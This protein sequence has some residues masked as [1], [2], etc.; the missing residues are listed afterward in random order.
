V[1]VVGAVAGT[2]FVVKNHSSRNDANALCTTSGCPASKRGEITSL[3]A[4]ANT[5]AT[6]AWVSYGVGA[7]GLATGAVLFLL[8]STRPA[9][10]QTARVKPWVS[11]QSAGCAVTF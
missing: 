4:S 10:A 6:L 9:A 5:A 8:S 7:A 3:D 2:V 1:G 11:G